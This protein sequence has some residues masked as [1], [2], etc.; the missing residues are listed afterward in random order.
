MSDLPFGGES[1]GELLSRVVADAEQ[2]ARAEIDLQK[3]RI[4]AKI[5]EARNAIVLSLAAMMLGSLMLTAL[6]VGALL[7]LSR[8]VGPLWSTVIV[9][10]VLAA[11]AG[12]CGWFALQMF[13]SLFGA[14]EAAK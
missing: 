14:P 1:I 5:G 8:A 9:A 4:A 12:L 6:V 3:A 10:G 2:V 7:T 13:R 11:A